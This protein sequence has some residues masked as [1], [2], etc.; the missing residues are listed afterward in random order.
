M[1]TD[2]HRAVLAWLRAVARG[3]A[4]TVYCTVFVQDVSIAF[5]INQIANL[6][7]GLVRSTPQRL[8][9][10]ALSVLGVPTIRVRKKLTLR[11]K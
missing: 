2:E 10:T 4:V 8:W 5:A 11:S 1:I 7:T 3:R 9:K 6:S